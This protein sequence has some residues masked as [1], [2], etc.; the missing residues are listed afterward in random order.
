MLKPTM[1][2]ALDRALALHSNIRPEQK[3]LKVANALAYFCTELITAV[4]SL[5][6]QPPGAFTIK[7]YTAVT[8]TVLE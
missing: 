2:G 1:S 5:M 6:I 7:L 4:N 3:R 8:F